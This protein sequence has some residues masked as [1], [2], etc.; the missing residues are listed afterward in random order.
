MPILTQSSTA[1]QRRSWLRLLLGV[2][3]VACSVLA[4]LVWWSWERPVRIGEGT[5]WVV[6]GR[7]SYDPKDMDIEWGPGYSWW[8][9]RL[10]GD[11]GTVLY[12]VG[13]RWR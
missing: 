11:P 13:L 12:G 1:S 4:G 6:F 7:R 10:P 2:P 5:R 9:F 8:T 3:V